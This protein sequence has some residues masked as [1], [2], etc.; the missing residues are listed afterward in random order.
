M[1]KKKKVKKVL[2]DKEESYTVPWTN[3]HTQEL[4]KESQKKGG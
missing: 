3:L 2:K 1:T 4:I